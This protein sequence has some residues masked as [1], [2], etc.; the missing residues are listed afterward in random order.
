[1]SRAFAEYFSHID[2]FP[3]RQELFPGL[4]WTQIFMHNYGWFHWKILFQAKVRTGPTMPQEKIIN[5][6]VG[7]DCV[8][9]GPVSRRPM[10]YFEFYIQF[11]L[12]YWYIKCTNIKMFCNYK[13]FSLNVVIDFFKIW[14]KNMSE[15]RQLFIEIVFRG[16]S[17]QKRV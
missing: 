3:D 2:R 1:M 13:R 7:T 11:L 9:S 17:R 15:S 16:F 8:R 6:P 10:T 14:I 5:C 12:V 4:A